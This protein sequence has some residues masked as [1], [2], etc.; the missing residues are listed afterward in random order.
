M[1]LPIP[2]AHRGTG[3]EGGVPV[4]EDRGYLVERLSEEV[5][6]E[7]RCS[8][9]E[10]KGREMF[11]SGRGRSVSGKGRV[12]KGKRGVR[13]KEG[14][15]GK[16]KGRLKKTFVRGGRRREGLGRQ[17][18]KGKKKRKWMPGGRVA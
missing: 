9:E 4:E 11:V 8:M 3:K 14:V 2:N 7:F 6:E 18:E 17:Q 10:K 15:V 13:G 12:T 1:C 5:K 16:T